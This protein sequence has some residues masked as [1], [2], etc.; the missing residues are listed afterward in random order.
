MKLLIRQA[1]S[2]ALLLPV[3]SLAEGATQ[4]EVGAT[5]RSKADAV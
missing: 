4:R 3:L 2:G 5:L 1:A